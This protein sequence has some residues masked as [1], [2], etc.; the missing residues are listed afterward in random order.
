MSFD[1]TALRR[2]GW[3]EGVPVV[4][5][6]GQAWHLPRPVIE[7]YYDVGE[8]GQIEIRRDS[9]GPQVDDELD[10]LVNAGEDMEKHSVAMYRMARTLLLHNYDLGADHLRTLLRIYP[11][12]HPR[13]EENCG[14]W[15]A[16]YAVGC[17]TVPKASPVG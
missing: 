16:I 7:Y 13:F 5:C 8:S 3:R 4:L 12:D 9:L 2:P 10:A 17:G 6:D 15:E 11:K 1:E 14:M